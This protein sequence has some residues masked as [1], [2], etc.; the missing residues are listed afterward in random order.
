VILFLP[1]SLYGRYFKEQ[2]TLMQEGF[3]KLSGKKTKPA[4]RGAEVK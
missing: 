4:V 3:E 2:E 1:L